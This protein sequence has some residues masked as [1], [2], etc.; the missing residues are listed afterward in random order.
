MSRSDWQRVED[1]YDHGLRVAGM[2]QGTDPE[3][4]ADGEQLRV[5]VTHYLQIMGEAARM[6]PH[7]LRDRLPEVPWRKM[8]NIRNTIVH[9]YDDVELDPLWDFVMVELPS[10]IELLHEALERAK[11]RGEL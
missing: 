3:D 5:T 10:I 9:R 11:S 8:V 4:F 7:E 1:I 2:L 6:V